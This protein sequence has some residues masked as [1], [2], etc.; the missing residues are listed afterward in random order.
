M[1]HSVLIYDE[2]PSLLCQSS[3]LCAILYYFVIIVI[4]NWDLSL[5][6]STAKFFIFLWLLFFFSSVTNSDL[7]KTTLYLYYI[8]GIN[9]FVMR[10][11]ILM[12]GILVKLIIYWV[13]IYIHCFFKHAPSFLQ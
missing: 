9:V 1:E 5:E 13:Y 3:S 10:A 12:Y 2:F 11:L 6:I 8:N 4:V 7:N